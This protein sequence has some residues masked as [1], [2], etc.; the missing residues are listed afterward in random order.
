M[1]MVQRTVFWVDVKEL[2]SEMVDMA[3]KQ[4]SIV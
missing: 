3:K 1:M 2:P 4:H